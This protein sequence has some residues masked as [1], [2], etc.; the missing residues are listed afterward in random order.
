[1][2]KLLLLGD[3]GHAHVMLDTLLQTYAPEDLGIVDIHTVRGTQIQQVTVLGTDDDL[4]A[5]FAAGYT[6]AAIGVGSI[7]S[8]AI[9]KKIT[10][11][12]K[13]IGFDLPVIQDSSALV[14][15]YAQV[16]EGS[17]IGKRAVVQPGARIGSLCILNTASIVEHDCVVEDFCHIAC[18]TV[19]LGNVHVQRESFIG[20]G[21]VVRQGIQVGKNTVVGA[22]SVVTGNLPDNAVAYGNP[23]R[24]R[25]NR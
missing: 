8:C 16:G 22:G 25:K 13:S 23:C 21:S 17:F 20:G 9:R 2:S 19:L 14:S 4:P 6:Q 24:V 18:G 15:K 3:G 1:M 5:L 12:L 11:K 10:E 7:E